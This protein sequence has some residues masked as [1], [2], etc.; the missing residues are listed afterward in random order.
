MWFSQ[1]LGRK[2][3]AR[4]V[5]SC[6]LSWSTDIAEAVRRLQRKGQDIL[7]TNATARL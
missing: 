7:G 6:E 4:P 5:I 3:P 1:T 2:P